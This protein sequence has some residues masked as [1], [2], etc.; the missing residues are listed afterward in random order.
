[1]KNQLRRAQEVR[2]G[3]RVAAPEGPLTVTSTRI[4]GVGGGQVSL[5][6]AERRQRS[7][8]RPDDLIEVITPRPPRD[9]AG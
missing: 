3:D 4:E 9:L 5:G 7:G 6:F 2:I 1:M 8:F